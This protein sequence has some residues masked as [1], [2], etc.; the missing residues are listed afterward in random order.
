MPVTCYHCFV[1]RREMVIPMLRGVLA[2]EPEA[3]RVYNIISDFEAGLRKAG[4]PLLCLC[5]DHQFRAEGERPS[6][7][8]IAE[9]LEGPSGGAKRLVAGICDPC[10][11]RYDDSALYQRVGKT[12]GSGWNVVEAG[13]MGR[14]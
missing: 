7:L 8:V 14:A 5:C 6:A 10:A 1:M 2:D 13:K 4:R 12:F 3:C 11:G 9:L